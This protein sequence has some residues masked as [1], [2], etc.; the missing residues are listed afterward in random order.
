MIAV[1]GIAYMILI[2]AALGVLEGGQASLFRFNW[3]GCRNWH[4]N[5]NNNKNKRSFLDVYRINIFGI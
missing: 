3:N 5:W 1:T 2:P 4:S